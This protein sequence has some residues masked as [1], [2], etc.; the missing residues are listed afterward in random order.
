MAESADPTDDLSAALRRVADEHGCS[1]A[2]R[3][4][5]PNR[6]PVELAAGLANRAEGIANTPA[7]RFGVASITKGFT[8]LTIQSLIADGLLT[9]DATLRDILGD[10]LPNVDPAVTIEHLL[11][12]RSGV[13]DFLDESQLGDIDDHVLGGRSAHTFVR[14]ID[15]LPL[16]AHLPQTSPPGE[17]F[18]YNNGAFVMLSMVIDELTDSFH[19]AVVERVLRPAGMA[20]SGFFRSDDLPGNTALGYLQDG[21]TNVLHLPVIGAGDGGIYLAAGD[22]VR[23]W[24]TLRTGRIVEAATVD[25][26]TTV[27]T[28]DADDGGTAYGRGFWLSADADH[29]WLEGMDAGVSAQTG[30]IR[31]SGITY[32]VL[33]NTSSG[34]WPMVRALLERVAPG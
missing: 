12:H 29:V 20:E 14:P 19:D 1:G 18:A 34:A 28:P 27:V 4:D 30:W 10:Q 11:T 9:A 13:G 23:F 6:S 7:T 33:S 25:S 24:E 8:A 2:V 22:C 17:R 21:R 31:S 15:Y 32:A 16:M 3:I 26:T 5:V